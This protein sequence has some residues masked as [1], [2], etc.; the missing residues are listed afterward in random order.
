M[1]FSLQFKVYLLHAHKHRNSVQ[2]SIFEGNYGTYE[3]K[4]NFVKSPVWIEVMIELW[5]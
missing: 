2:S 4:R 1:W 5:L 3:L